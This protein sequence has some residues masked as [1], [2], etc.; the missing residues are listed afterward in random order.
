[1]RGTPI[2]KHS[3][4]QMKKTKKIDKKRILLVDG[5]NLLHRGFHKFAHFMTRNRVRTGAIYGFFMV[6]QSNIE[7]FKPDHVIICFDQHRSKH[8]LE[9]YP[10]YKQRKLM[11]GMDFKSLNQQKRVILR[12]L[13][14]L[15]IPY[16]KDTKLVNQHECDDYM[17]WFVINHMDYQI[18]LL[19]SDEDFVQLV[20]YDHVKVISPNKDAVISRNSC[21]RYF[22]YDAYFAVDHKILTGDSSDNIKGYPGIGPK[23]A[24]KFLEK[25]HSVERFLKY[26]NDTF[27]R[28]DRNK[29]SEV[30]ELNRFLVDLVYY[31]ELYPLNKQDIPWHYLEDKKINWEYFSLICNEYQLDSFQTTQFINTFNRLKNAKQII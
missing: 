29:L 19:S 2:L 3:V 13:R 20:N 7:R 24:L 26:S 17:A 18:Y 28:V 21:E 23:T 1:M 9:R 27:Q 12:M 10:E 11:L 22:G 31:L 8:R 5:N 15:R 4:I 16:I 30:Y 25:Y 14:M 6:L